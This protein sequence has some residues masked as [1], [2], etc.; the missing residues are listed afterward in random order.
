MA[1]VTTIYETQAFTGDK[2]LDGGLVDHH[3]ELIPVEFHPYTDRDR[4][5]IVTFCNRDFSASR[6]T[7]KKL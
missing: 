6:V 1:P 2:S 7:V 4:I 5:V 3:G